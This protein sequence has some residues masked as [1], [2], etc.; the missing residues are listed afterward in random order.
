MSP[1]RRTT[2][3]HAIWRRRALA[4][5]L[6][7]TLVVSVAIASGEDEDNRSTGVKRRPR[8]GVLAARAV[9]APGVDR[10]HGQLA[11]G[12]LQPGSDPSV[13]PGPVLIA[14]RDNNR[15]VEVSP[16]GRVLWRFPA[17]GDLAPG[18]TF[19][20]PDDAFFSPDGRRVIVTQEDD[21][22]I[23]VLDVASRRIV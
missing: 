3:R 8:H 18:Q 14:D 12:G 4:L 5:A 15:L 19:L 1:P 9:Q 17:A 22:V 16:D 13:L 10:V 2:P 7:I 20:L 23:S 21:N 6:P 11:A